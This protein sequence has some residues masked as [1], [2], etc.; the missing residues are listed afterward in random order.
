M[1]EKELTPYMKKKLIEKIEL[2]VFK[3]R[4]EVKRGNPR[5]NLIEHWGH[6]IQIRIEK[7]K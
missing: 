5:P 3:I 2:Y 7:L 1:T 6:N 4:N